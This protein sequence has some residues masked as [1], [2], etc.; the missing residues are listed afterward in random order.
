M[1]ELTDGQFIEL[2][3]NELTKMAHEFRDKALTASK[4]E[5]KNF[6]NVPLILKR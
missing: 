3:K 6:M 1:N 2:Q 4:V 5:A